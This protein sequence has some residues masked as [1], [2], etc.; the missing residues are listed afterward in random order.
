MNFYTVGQR[1]ALAVF[2]KE[3]DYA[4]SLAGFWGRVA[5]KKTPMKLRAGLGLL[6]GLQ[7]ALAGDTIGE[8]LGGAHRNKL[9][10]GGAGLGAGYGVHNAKKVFDD[11]VQNR[12]A[13]ALRNI[14]PKAGIA[15]GA[16]G[17]AG[18]AAAIAHHVLSNKDE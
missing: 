4:D 18:A 8:A 14:L 15:V 13:A 10:I 16:L 12:R 6:G 9:T 17:A 7:G 5:P 11:V 2:L 1:D 3:A